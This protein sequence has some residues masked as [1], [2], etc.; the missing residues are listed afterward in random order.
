MVLLCIYKDFTPIA[1]INRVTA[2]N[3]RKVSG[4]TALN[5]NG[6]TTVPYSIREVFIT[7]V[8]PILY[9]IMV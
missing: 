3:R 2:L 4:V 8:V 5:T 9:G 7:V 1:N 6:I